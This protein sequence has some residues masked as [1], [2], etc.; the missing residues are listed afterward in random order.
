VSADTNENLLKNPETKKSP[1]T[2]FPADLLLVKFETPCLLMVWES[3]RFFV[4]I[5][6]C[7]NYY[8]SKFSLNR[9]Y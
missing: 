9:I 1:E 7:L 4:N 8:S 3:L 2:K 6:V 5:L